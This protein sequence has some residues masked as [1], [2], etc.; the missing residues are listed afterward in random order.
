LTGILAHTGAPNTI[1]TRPELEELVAE[2]A[3]TPELWEPHIDRSSEQRMYAC[4]RRDTHV[5]IW[6]IFW[7]PGND[8][9]WHDHDT[10]SGAVHVVEGSL[11]NRELRLG[12]PDR[13]R[14]YHAGESFS[15]DPAQIHRLVCESET[16]ISIHA[17]SA[18]LWR[19]GQYSV[20]PDGMLRRVSVTY[21]DELRPLELRV[22]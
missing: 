20:D 17:Y 5:D 22:A 4:L 16:A 3:A 7:R 13:R 2:I 6:A 19:L 9:G 10:S 14:T 15:F 11:T 18:P 12:G 21:A 8:T 1:L